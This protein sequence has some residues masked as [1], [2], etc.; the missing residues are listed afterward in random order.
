MEDWRGRIGEPAYAL[1]A[2]ILERSVDSHQA[3]RSRMTT[4]MLDR[5]GHT[6]SGS[7][8]APLFSL[9]GHDVLEFAQET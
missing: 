5:R 6:A 9:I 4:W 7:R 1:A 2:A 8:P 3:I